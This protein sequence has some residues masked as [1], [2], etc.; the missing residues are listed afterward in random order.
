MMLTITHTNDGDPSESRGHLMHTFQASLAPG[1]CYYFEG[2]DGHS[3][4]VEVDKYASY[5]EKD[6]RIASGYL[7]SKDA[8]IKFD[9]LRVT[10]LESP[11]SVKVVRYR[12]PVTPNLS[13]EFTLFLRLDNQVRFQNYYRVTHQGLLHEGKDADLFPWLT[14]HWYVKE[15]QEAGVDELLKGVISQNPGQSE[16]Q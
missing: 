2:I 7:G 13:Y 8:L 9:Y 16:P 11:P 5:G 15:V 10:S 12:C 1:D 4:T 14:L 6:S 3:L